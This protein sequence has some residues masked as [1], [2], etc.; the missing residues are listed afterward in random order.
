[1]ALDSY[2][3]VVGYLKK[4]KKLGININVYR[5]RMGGLK[6]ISYSQEEK[7]TAINDMMIVYMQKIEDAEKER[8]EIEDFVSKNFEG[9]DKIIIYEKFINDT[10]YIKIGKIIGYDNS[11][12][13]KR[14]KKAIY[15][16][17]SK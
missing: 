8:K 5:H 12:C 7:G 9:I 14:M 3:K 4:Y 15:K 17:L 16:Y 6:A 1:M 11:Y 2:E 13:S 10:T